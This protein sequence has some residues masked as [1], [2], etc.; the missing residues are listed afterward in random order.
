MDVEGNR[1]LASLTPP[2]LVV[3]VRYVAGGTAVHTTSSEL[4]PE[5]IHVRTAWPLPPGRVIPLQLYFPNHREP[6]TP[7]SIVAERTSGANPGFWAEFAGNDG[8]KERIS[9]LM[10]LHREGAGRMFQRFH[11]QLDASVRQHEQPPAE[12]QLSNISQTG[13]FVRLATPPPKGAVVELDVAFGAERHTVLGY[14]VHMAPRRGI[15][16]QFIGASD[17]FQSHLDRHLTGLARRGAG[18]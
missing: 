7:V 18:T 8:I 4:N 16:V 2:R 15:G 9:A 10:E 1:V 13:A 14:V 17:G 11:T 6:L 5:A 12:A 3:P